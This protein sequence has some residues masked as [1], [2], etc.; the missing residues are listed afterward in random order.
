MSAPVRREIHEREVARVRAEAERVTIRD[1]LAA[2]RSRHHLPSRRRTTVILAAVADVRLDVAL[3]ALGALERR[4][5]VT[6][7]ICIHDGAEHMTWRL[8]DED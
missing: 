2:L 3:Q 4:G 6:S 8:A 1:L 7:E 5:E